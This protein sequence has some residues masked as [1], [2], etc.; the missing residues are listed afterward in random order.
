M[1][2]EDD[3]NLLGFLKDEEFTEFS[4]ENLLVH[5]GYINGPKGTILKLEEMVDEGIPVYEQR[6]AIHNHRNFRRFISLEKFEELRKFS[7]KP[8]DVII[9]T[10]GTV[11][12]TSVIEDSD[13]IGVIASPLLILRINS[14]RILPQSRRRSWK[15]ARKQDAGEKT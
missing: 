12:K 9:S 2:N 6:H 13:E 11:G 10:S 1:L 5:K 4:L 3:S 8:N 14:K 7:V 15:H